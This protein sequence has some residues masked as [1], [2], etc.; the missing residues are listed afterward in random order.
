M[1]EIKQINEDNLPIYPISVEKA[2]FDENGI[3]LDTKVNNIVHEAP[4]DSFPYARK[5]GAWVKMELDDLVS[6]L[7]T[8]PEAP[9]DENSYLRKNGSWVVFNESDINNSLNNKV[10]E[11][12]SDS[13][14]YVRKNGSWSELNFTDLNLEVG[15]DNVQSDWSVSDS[16][17]DAYIANKPTTQDELG[18]A[19]IYETR[20]RGSNSVTTL[21]NLPVNKSLIIANLSAATNISLSAGMNVGES[22]TI[23][24]TPSSNFTQPIPTSGAFVSMD[25]DSLDIKSGV[26]FEM[27]ILCIASGSYSISCKVAI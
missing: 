11:A 2:I 17:S 16:S 26:K 19:E 27:N 9:I 6:N 10:N 25:G 22:V 4:K 18:I 13:K 3:R 15:E 20:G 8:V 21:S 12:P 1:A 14:P 24:A 23:I 7:D 5:D